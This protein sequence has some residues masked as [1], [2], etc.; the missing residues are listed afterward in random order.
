MR[1]LTFWSI[2][3]FLAAS[4]CPA[5]AA[6]DLV[7]LPTRDATQLTIYNSEDITMV[8]EHRLLTVNEGVICKVHLP[9]QNR[10]SNSEPDR[11]VGLFLLAEFNKPVTMP[12]PS[13][14]HSCHFGLGQFGTADE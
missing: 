8:R 2:V 12:L 3:V 4:A 14:G 11:R 13:F 9:K 1:N 7:T 10:S 5:L 6:V